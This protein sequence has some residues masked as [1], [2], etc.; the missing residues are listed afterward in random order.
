MAMEMQIQPLVSKAAG[1][2]ARGKF[3]VLFDSSE[4]ESQAD[5]VLHASFATPEKIALLRSEAGG[6]V[7]LAT[8]ESVAQTLEIPFLA[9]ALKK[10]GLQNVYDKTPYGDYPPFSIPI[11]H[12]NAFTGVTDEDR[13]LAARKF[14]ELAMRPNKKAFV[15]EFRTPG[16]LPLLASRGLEKRKGHTEMSVKLCELA[17][18][19]PAVLLCEML[20]FGKTLSQ[21]E[22]EGKATQ[23]GWMLVKGEDFKVLE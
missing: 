17:G 4:R 5:L 6:L 10:S 14:F 18:L 2:L 12:K 22:I 19:P 8:S 15:E 11:N 16:H 3:L 1:E 7:C 9:H 13:A 20:G 21:E 23:N